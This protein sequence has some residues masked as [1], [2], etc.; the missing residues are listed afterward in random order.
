[1]KITQ[2]H[3]LI[4]MCQQDWDPTQCPCYWGNER[5]NCKA[6]DTFK[7]AGKKRAAKKKRKPMRKCL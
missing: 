5:I 4:C 7:S 3:D 1:M 6:N 2:Q